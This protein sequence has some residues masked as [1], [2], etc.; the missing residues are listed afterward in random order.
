LLCQTKENKTYFQ[1]FMTLFQSQQPNKRELNQAPVQNDGIMDAATVNALTAAALGNQFN[2]LRELLAQKHAKFSAGPQFRY[3]EGVL[4]AREGRFDAALALLED[5]ANRAPRIPA[6]RYELG[7]VLSALGRFTDA[8]LA[9]ESAI[10]LNKNFTAA[11][12]NLGKARLSLGEIARA[13][14]ALTSAMALDQNRVDVWQA[15]ANVHEQAGFSERAIA[16]LQEARRRFGAEANRDAE[17]L[18]VLISA[19]KTHQTV[20]LLTEI[21]AAKPDDAIA[22]YLLAV[23]NGSAPLRA[24]PRYVSTL[25]DG[26]AAF[27]DLHTKAMRN[28][29]TVL[30]AQAIQQH[31]PAPGSVLDLGCGTGLAAA[32]L[33][34]YT[35]TGVDLSSAML[36]QARLRAD[37]KMS[38][39]Y[40][41]L[42]QQDLSEFL[43]H[44]ADARFDV[45][46]AIDTLNYFGPLLEIFKQ[47][48][49]V[50]SSG[51]VLCVNLETDTSVR[52]YALQATGSF[53]HSSSYLR[54]CCQQAGLSVMR[55]TAVETRQEGA[56]KVPGLLLVAG[57]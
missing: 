13:E 46:T 10:L 20:E 6:P 40:V 50:L 29:A 51:G 33:P 27:F 3:W 30:V 36:A 14:R 18:R 11:W 52:E 32:E 55:I 57:A 45:I 7:N 54:S 22:A 16:V 9:F 37:G 17:L 53:I 28:Q 43:A 1:A 34:G 38:Q 31:K 21:L 56:K 49:R 5:A 35:L 47:V 48:K 24:D 8:A 19:G 25:F 4:A 44:S 15:L 23:N 41:A 12:I 39:S 42:H 26:Y 2:V